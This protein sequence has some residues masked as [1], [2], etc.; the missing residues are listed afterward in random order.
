MTIIKTLSIYIPDGDVVRAVRNHL[1]REYGLKKTV[2]DIN[3]DGS[4]ITFTV[5]RGLWKG[6]WTAPFNPESIIGQHD[7]YFTQ[8]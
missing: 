4:Q 1:A 6:V 8:E 2:E 3:Y 5:T 7:I